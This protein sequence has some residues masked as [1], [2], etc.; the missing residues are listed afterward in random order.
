MTEDDLHSPWFNT[1]KPT[2]YLARVDDVNID[3]L[4]QYLTADDIIRAERFRYVTDQQLHM[5]AHS[6]KRFVLSQYL[7][8]NPASLTFATEHNGKPVCNQP[9]AP[10]F[11]LSHSQGW[12]AL[13]VSPLSPVG[14]DIEH[15]RPNI[16]ASDIIARIASPQEV[17]LYQQSSDPE[18][19][20]LCLWTQKEA[21]SKACGKGLSVGA[22]SIPCSGTIGEHQLTFAGREYWSCTFAI[23]PSTV[24]SYVEACIPKRQHVSPTFIRVSGSTR[25]ES[26][27]PDKNP[28]FEF[29]EFAL[30]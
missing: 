10:Y 3:A 26:T 21:I 30:Y 2:V 5:L 22:S 28:L 25:P 24:L 17:L 15:A 29:G 11:N 1:Q 18:Q 14:V 6:L 8:I 19:C 16:S 9:N 20:F 4:S 7:Q 27:R 23:S 12:V 13:A